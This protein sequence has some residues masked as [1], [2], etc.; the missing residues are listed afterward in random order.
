MYVKMVHEIT[1]AWIITHVMSNQNSFSFPFRKHK[2]G[3]VRDMLPAD[4]IGK[5]TSIYKC[6]HS[7]KFELLTLNAY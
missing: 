2:H 7:P 6:T 5:N 4:S 3:R 1:N